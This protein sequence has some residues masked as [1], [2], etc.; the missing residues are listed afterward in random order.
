MGELSDVSLPDLVDLFVK[1]R[2]TGKLTVKADGREVDLYIVDGALVLASTSDLTLRLGRM[3]IRLG[4]INN[5]QLLDALHEQTETPRPRSLGSILRSR[6]LVS[7]NQLACCV[8]EQCI[9]VL[10]RVVTA[11]HGVFLYTDGVVPP[12]KLETAPLDAAR[13]LSEAAERTE[14]LRRLRT[15]LPAPTA[16]L[17][18]DERQLPA[19]DALTEEEREVIR[20][21]RLGA[22]SLGDLVDQ[23]SL[24]E[25]T[26]G[27]A[28]LSLSTRGVILGKRAGRAAATR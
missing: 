2:R 28:V 9:E 18:F 8:E 20:V 6:G 27:A 5:Q 4:I 22:S 16:P 21:L 1:R 10:S 14:Q 24:D 17:L 7:P 11:Q 26:L 25:A 15:L 13:V 23:L 3:L 19:A 12:R